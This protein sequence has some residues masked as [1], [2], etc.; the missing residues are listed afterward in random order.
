MPF[1]VWLKCV[2]NLRCI[3]QAMFNLR[4]AIYFVNKNNYFT[5]DWRKGV[6]ILVVTLGNSVPILMIY[7]I[8]QWIG[9]TYI[10]N[11]TYVGET[12]T[13]QWG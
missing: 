7:H 12:K 11:C 9:F 1:L 8:Q 3:G 10:F 4:C 5:F 13:E 6:V 2:R